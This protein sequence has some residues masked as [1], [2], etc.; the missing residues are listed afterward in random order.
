[1]AELK[2]KNLIFFGA[3]GAGKGTMANALKAVHPVAHISTGDLLRD[4]IKRDTELGRA[5]S[6]IMK[7]G[8]LVPDEIVADMVRARLSQPDC[9][10]GFILDGYPRT[11]PQAHLLDKVL[12][13]LGLTLDCVVYL[14]VA[15]DVI[16]QRLTA[17]V[18]C[19][20]CKAIYNRLFMP[21]KKEGVC[22]L[23]GGELIQRADDSLETAQNRLKVFYEQT[24]PLLDLYRERGLVYERSELDLDKATRMLLDELEK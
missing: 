13:D 22:D 5:A 9:A 21:P 14:K 20:D 15:D 17:R 2:K 16:L 12:A 19:K 7:A 10:N 3:P 6:E 23:C 24:S 8:K 11:V 4:E 18:S 1:M